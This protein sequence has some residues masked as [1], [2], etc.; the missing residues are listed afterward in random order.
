M[1]SPSHQVVVGTRTLMIAL[2]QLEQQTRS[3][4]LPDVAPGSPCWA[5]TDRAAGLVQAGLPAFAL[6]GT[7]LRPEPPYKVSEVPGF[8]AGTSNASS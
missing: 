7:Q 4:R 8:A 5:R 3:L 2:V 1:T 6:T